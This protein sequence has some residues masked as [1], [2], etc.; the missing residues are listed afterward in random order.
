MAP[1]LPEIESLAKSCKYSMKEKCAVQV[2]IPWSMMT[3]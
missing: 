3:E 2:Y 1:P